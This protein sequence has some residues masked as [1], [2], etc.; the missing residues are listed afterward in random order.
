MTVLVVTVTTA[1]DIIKH[2]R[3]LLLALSHCAT[4]SSWAGVVLQ[5]IERSIATTSSGS[6]DQSAT[7]VQ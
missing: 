7:A 3:H 5:R 2:S 4:V 6:T 1:K